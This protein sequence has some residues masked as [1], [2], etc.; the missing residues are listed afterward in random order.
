M[1]QYIDI[2]TNIS[3]PKTQSSSYIQLSHQTS[4]LLIK[5]SNHYHSYTTIG[6]TICS[7]DLIDV[8]C[9]RLFVYIKGWS[10]TVSLLGYALVDMKLFL[11]SHGTSPKSKMLLEISTT[12]KWSVKSPCHELSDSNH[13][14]LGPLFQF[15]NEGTS[16]P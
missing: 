9:T 4:L 16:H 5:T 11:L 3:L 13:I 10:A 14:N 6:K 2:V 1:Q 8:L 12:P 7:C 15:Y